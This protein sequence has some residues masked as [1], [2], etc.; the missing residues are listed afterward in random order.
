MGVGC[1]R[2]ALAALS[3]GKSPGTHCTGGWVG[4]GAGLDGCEKSRPRRDSIP[5]PPSS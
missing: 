3:P 1:Q 4:L 5:G 2:V